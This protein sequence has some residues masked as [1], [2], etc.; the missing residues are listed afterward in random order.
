VLLELN[1]GLPFALRRSDLAGVDPSRYVATLLAKV[2]S[3]SPDTDPRSIENIV[4]QY[5]LQT[6]AQHGYRPQPYAGTLVL[7]EPAG[8]HCGLLA[9]QFSPFVQDL[10]NVSLPIGSRSD[11]ARLLSEAFDKNI[12]AHYW[13][14]RDEL[15]VNGLAT[16]LDRLL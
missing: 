15:S 6:R 10:R 1:T 16:E 14:M 7:F 13:S 2:A 9:S 3:V 4:V 12:Q 5:Y 11:Q 8:P